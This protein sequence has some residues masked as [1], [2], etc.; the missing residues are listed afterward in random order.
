M[1]PNL[2]CPHL[3]ESTNLLF[4]IWSAASDVIPFKIKKENMDPVKIMISS[5]LYMPPERYFSSTILRKNGLLVLPIYNMAS[6]CIRS[7]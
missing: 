4:R 1:A 2:S 7:S 6:L 5:R 3:H